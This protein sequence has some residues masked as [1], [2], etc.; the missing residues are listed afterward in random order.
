MCCGLCLVL[1]AARVL[2][3]GYLPAM[4][5][6]RLRSPLNLLRFTISEGVLIVQI[7]LR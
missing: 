7:A 6:R 5:A 4:D 1:H 2:I 3:P